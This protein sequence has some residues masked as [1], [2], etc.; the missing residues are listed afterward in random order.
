MKSKISGIYKNPAAKAIGIYTFT[1]FFAKGASFLLLF[2][3]TNPLYISP[4]ENGLLN[5]MSTSIIFLM[6]FVSLGSVHSINADYFKLD[7]KDFRDSF[8]TSLLLPVSVTLV[9]FMVLFFFRERLLTV[10]GFPFSFV[11]IIPS[12]VLFNFCYEHLMNLIR[13]DNDT[14]RFLKVNVARTLIEISLSVILVVFFAW[15]WQGR[16]AGIFSAYTLV[17]LY[18]VYYFRKKNY[19]FGKVSRERLL[20][21]LQ[22]AGPIVIMQVS[23]FCLSSSDKFFLSAFTTDNNETVGIY[24]IA[25]IFASVITIFCTAVL[26]YFFPKIYSHLS[27]E[28]TDYR[29]IRK[30]FLL[31]AGIMCLCLLMMLIATPVAYKFFIHEK[32]HKA[33]YFV[34]YLC[35][36]CFIWAINYFFYSSMLFFKEKKK[37]LAIS[38]FSIVTS[39]S[40]NYFFIKQWKELGAA[41]SFLLS[42]TLVFVVTLF[43]NSAFVRKIFTSTPGNQI[44]NS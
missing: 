24:S 10:Y 16:V 31:Y 11:W 22:Y 8:T 3:Y 23:I 5:L 43:V 19:L 14:G 40:L 32:Y 25:S 37:I 39:L 35:L 9:S 17:F 4:S 13:N 20:H 44:K 30:Y 6:P 33:L 42:Y 36:G 18:A 21:E 12:I 27:G 1:N 34:P 15:R 38:V 29:A 26:H 2:I 28:H 41:Q 7:A